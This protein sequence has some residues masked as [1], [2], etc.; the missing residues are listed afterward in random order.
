MR[1]GSGVVRIVIVDGAGGARA[2]SDVSGLR[3]GSSR[4]DLQR[5]VDGTQEKM[6][7]RYRGSDGEDDGGKMDSRDSGNDG[8]ETEG[9]IDSRLG[10]NDGNAAEGEIQSRPCSKYRAG[11]GRE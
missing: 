5:S 3:A 7:S 4:V 10:R 8:A 9:E 2:E 6:D 11:L 1:L